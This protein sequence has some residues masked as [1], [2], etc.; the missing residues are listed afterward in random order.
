[1]SWGKSHFRGSDI[2]LLLGVF[3]L[4][5]CEVH[6]N[7]ALAM[8][9]GFLTPKYESHPGPLLF[10]NHKVRCKYPKIFIREHFWQED[11][12]YF[13]DAAVHETLK[14][15]VQNLR[16]CPYFDPYSKIGHTLDLKIFCFVFSLRWSPHVIQLCKGS[17]WLIISAVDAFECSS[18]GR[19]DGA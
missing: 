2:K 10:V 4:L 12:E 6:S 15:L 18:I 16:C 11:F 8:P 13:S 5:P 19:D 14:F 17:L 1:M 3:R 9:F 7:S